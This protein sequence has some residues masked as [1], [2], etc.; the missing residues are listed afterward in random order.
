MVPPFESNN[1]TKK[2]DDGTLDVVSIAP[3][4]METPMM[5]GMPHHYS[6]T[7]I[8][9]MPFPRRFG[10]PAEYAALV[11]HIVDNRLLNGEVIRLDAALRMA[12]SS[13]R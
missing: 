7:L 3:G 2:Q 4:G 5:A 10:S 6:D 9:D 1:T 13:L 12:P 8:A 11:A